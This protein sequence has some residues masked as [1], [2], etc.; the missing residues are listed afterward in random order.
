MHTVSI[1]SV[2]TV[3]PAIYR[4]LIEKPHSFRFVPGHSIMVSINKPQ[5]IL[6]KHPLTFTSIN[7][8]PYLEFYVKTY[9][10]RAS[11]N[12]LLA[13]LHPG[14]SLLLGETFGTIRYVGPGL[15]IA[16]GIGITPF[17]AIVRQLKKENALAGNTL[18]YSAQ[19]HADIVAEQELRSMLGNNIQ[20]TLTKEQRQGY[21]HGRI[22]SDFLQKILPVIPEHRYAIGSD[23]FVSDMCVLFGAT[24]S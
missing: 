16:G 15:M 9:P 11:F 22:T 14:D 8:D 18:V 24:R 12:N 19:F 20:F 17:L 3:A 23:S 1:I 21:S 2:E 5:F 6:E 4:L 13:A 10:A 7:D